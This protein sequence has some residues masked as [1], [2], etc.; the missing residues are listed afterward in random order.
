MKIAEISLGRN[1]LMWG[2]EE[3]QPEGMVEETWAE[4]WEMGNPSDQE[5]L[6]PM[7]H[8]KVPVPSSNISQK[9]LLFSPSRRFPP[10]LSD[11]GL[12]LRAVHCRME[13]GQTGALTLFPWIKSCFVHGA[14]PGNVSPW[15]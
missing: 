6:C 14:D 11:R 1:W 9:S 10:L 8:L 2:N 5:Q 3:S 12:V 7:L 4:P 15:K 13:M